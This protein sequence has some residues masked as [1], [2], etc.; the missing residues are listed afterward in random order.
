MAML[1]ITGDAVVDYDMLRY[2]GML[3]SEVV[4]EMP[5]FLD[6][7]ILCHFIFFNSHR[8]PL[9]GRP[10]YSFI[11]ITSKSMRILICEHLLMESLELKLVS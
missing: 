11:H 1:Y 2:Q 9:C 8:S 6:M 5:S 4:G 7:A 3:I 10:F